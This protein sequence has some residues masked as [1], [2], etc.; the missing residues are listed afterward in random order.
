MRAAFVTE[1]VGT[2]VHLTD[3]AVG[4]DGWKEARRTRINGSEIAAVMQISPF[5]SPF[6]LWHR[7]AGLISDTE[8]NDVMYWGTQ[9][10]PVIRAEWNKR[11]PDL[12]V[13]E[14]GQ[15]AHKDRDWQGGSPDGLG[16]GRLWEAK[17][18]R[19]S[20]EW[21]EEGTDEVP[22]YYRAQTL[23]YLDVFG[24]ELCD[25]SVLIAGSEYR[26]YQIRYDAD[27]ASAMR[28][29]ARAF[30]DTL[31]QNIQPPLDGHDATYEAVKE[32]HPDIDPETVELEADV[33][34]PYLDALAAYTDAVA[35]KR[36]RAAAVIAAMGS[37]QYATYQ[38]ERIASRVAPRTEAGSPFLRA[39]NGA[40]DKFRSAA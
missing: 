28:Q 31:E 34:V 13:A 14:T 24:F 26:E 3:A 9:L 23:W 6:S 2:A 32:L 5:D 1:R 33:A 21:G 40:A 11:H 37:A 12:A 36:H 8:T 17:T 38:R 7:K 22:V 10:E 29:A 4:S 19:T 18:A 39:E 20:D 15:W 25:L 27:E 35:E 30:L 16:N